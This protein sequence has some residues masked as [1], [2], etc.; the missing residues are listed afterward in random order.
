M[1]SAPWIFALFLF[2]LCLLPCGLYADPLAEVQ[3]RF[4]A[5]TGDVQLLS[6]GARDWIDAH[7][8]LPIESG[9]EIQTGDD[10]VAE[11]VLSEN[12][13]WVMQPDTHIVTEH[14]ETGRGRL[15]LPVGVLLG[16]VDSKRIAVPQRWEFNMPTAACA[17]RG[18]EF[19][20]DVS[21]P[22]EAHIGVFEGAVEIQAAES[23]TGEQPSVRLEAVQEA[24]APQKGAIRKS[25]R[26]SARMQTYAQ[27]RRD[28]ESRL[29][30]VQNTWSPYTEPVRIEIRRKYVPPPPPIRHHLPP[31]FHPR[32]SLESHD[33]AAA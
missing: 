32:T 18:T 1:K 19:A 15:S 10:G 20:L 26:L 25:V 29:L 9:D 6:Q 14:M 30:R 23:A 22:R 12:V 31:P 17:V 33:H 16:K 24:V 13:L 5:V 3:A 27:K 4:G 8:G 21:Q 28:L 7:E 2:A 11:I